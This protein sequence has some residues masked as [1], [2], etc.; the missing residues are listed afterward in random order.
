MDN[1]KKYINDFLIHIRIERNYS[2]QTKNTYEIALNIFNDFLQRSHLTVT[3]KNCIALFIKYLKEEKKNN[4]NTIAHR[5]AVLK[6][7][8]TYLVKRNIISKNKLP[9]IEKYK[10]T[11]KILSTPTQEEVDLFLKQIKIEYMEM[12]KI[13]ENKE[14]NEKEKAKDY[15]L[16]RDLTFFTLLGGT[17]LRISEALNIKLDD[18]NQIDDTIKITGKGSKERLNFFSIDR[19]KN[20]FNELLKVRESLGIESDFLFVSY[21]HRK[22]LTPRYIQK[23][24]KI[25]LIQLN[26]SPK[27]T[28]HSLRHFYATVSIEKGANIKAVSILLGHAHV[29]TTLKMYFHISREY[30]RQVF[31]TLNPF[32]SIFLTPEEIIKNRYELAVNF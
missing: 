11:K 12:K 10:K 17:G 20:L 3:E 2:E 23:I 4:D 15:S 21:Q 27:Y 18:I 13:I 19:I 6:S 28:P 24:M 25:N 31:E 22:K 29:S 26:I 7:F 9:V 32:S 8:F 14:A 1:L 30:L 5:L 16:I